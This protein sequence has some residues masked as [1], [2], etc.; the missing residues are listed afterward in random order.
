MQITSP[1][2]TANMNPE[3]CLTTDSPAKVPHTP[4]KQG[5]MHP[6]TSAIYYRAHVYPPNG[7]QTPFG[8]APCHRSRLRLSCSQENP[9]RTRTG[10]RQPDPV[11]PRGELMCCRVDHRLRVRDPGEETEAHLIVYGS[12]RPASK[13]LDKDLNHKCP[14]FEVAQVLAGFDIPQRDQTTTRRQRLPIWAEG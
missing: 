5:E 10:H 6:S 1:A 3:G 12:A 11:F 2:D 14:L 13:K 4:P 9:W 7:K 8:P